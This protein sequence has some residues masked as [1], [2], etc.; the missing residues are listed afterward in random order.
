[1]P[2][3]SKTWAVVLFTS[4][5]I[6]LFIGGVF[7]SHWVSHGRDVGR[8][9]AFGMRGA[10]RHMDA[11]TRSTMQRMWSEHAE[12]MRPLMEAMREA[13]MNA[14][15]A[16][17]AEP[18]DKTTLEEA[19]AL[20]RSASTASQE[21]FHAALADAAAELGPEQ[22]RSLFAAASRRLHRQPG[23]RRK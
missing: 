2:Q 16:I 15:D 22:R 7:V 14:V 21:A 12:E 3:M 19:L 17:G 9:H 6:N 13:R 4:L 8:S 23:A 1:M 20:T 5:A 11:E 10:S 18:F